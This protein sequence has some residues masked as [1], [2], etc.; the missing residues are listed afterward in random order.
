MAD[1]TNTRHDTR[2]SGRRPSLVLL[3]FGI[4]ALL[5]SGWALIGP[6]DLTGLDTGV[7]GWTVAGVAALVGIALVA[8]P[9]RRGRS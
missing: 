6:L 2:D 9:G 4:A 1:D 8:L 3:A 7:L 5:V